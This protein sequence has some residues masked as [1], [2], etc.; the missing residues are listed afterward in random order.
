MKTSRLAPGVLLVSAFT[1]EACS[2][3]ASTGASSSGSAS[4]S[5]KEGVKSEFKTS[6][7]FQ[8]APRASGVGRA[9]KSS[10]FQGKSLVKVGGKF[11]L[12]GS[13]AGSASGKASGSASG[14]A[15]GSGSLS[16]S[17]STKS[18]GGNKASAGESK[19]KQKEPVVEAPKTE[20]SKTE[21][22]ETEKPKTE[23]P[24]AEPKPE[25]PKPDT[26]KTETEKPKTEKPKAEPKPEKPKPE[27]KPEKPK[28][29]PEPTVE[30]T[31]E[32]E[33]PVDEP[34][35]DDP[36]EIEPIEPPEEP[37][38]NVFGYAEPVRGCFEGIV[39]PIRPNSQRLPTDFGK[40]SPISVV[41][42][43]EWDIPA[44]DWGQGFPGVE[45]K[46]EW[47]AIRYSGSFN[48]SQGGRWKFRISSDDGAKLYIDG[49]LVLEND[50][51]HAPR[52]RSAT[53]ELSP[54]DHDMVLE[55]FQGPR[56]FINLQLYATPP[57]GDEG[58]FSVR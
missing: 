34:P 2:F 48:V 52:V 20:K 35:V 7:H 32:P 9:T 55:Y 54:G 19:P 43:C 27:P 11:S 18:S 10:D 24:K 30:E 41:Y 46:F 21:K 29:E 15:S 14:K 51:V 56:Y 38:P 47:F 5:S 25:K 22:A 8:S 28:P 6:S 39:Y 44:R 4:A 42:A 12:T 16:G 45:D 33:P 26:P 36:S 49:K 50:G 57:G 37:P 31:P 17:G 13:L 53:V 1:L 58:I 3:S 40:L 23:K